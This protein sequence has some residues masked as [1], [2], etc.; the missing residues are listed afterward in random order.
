MTDL[1][2][3]IWHLTCSFNLDPYHTFK[4]PKIG[5]DDSSRLMLYGF[6]QGVKA[7]DQLPTGA[8]GLEEKRGPRGRTEED[9][10]RNLQLRLLTFLEDWNSANLPK[11][12]L[13]LTSTKRI[14]R[15][16]S[17]SISDLR[18]SR[19]DSP[20]FSRDKV[21][22]GQFGSSQRTIKH[23]ASCFVFNKDFFQPS[24]HGIEPFNKENQ[25]EQSS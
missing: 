11:L 4:Y 18:Q 19:E 24:N 23:L 1:A 20:P 10:S 17:A 9:S 13:D 7:W 2:L 15:R 14:E 5:V 3:K 6:G 12:V 22:I 16:I 25:K 8:L 21:E